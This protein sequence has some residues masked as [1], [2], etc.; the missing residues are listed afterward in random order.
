MNVKEFLEQY[1]RAD[2]RAKRLRREYEKE[3]CLIDTITSPL[4]SDGT[5]H[6]S[7]IS[8]TV[9]S[10][11]IRLADKLLEYEDAEL[12]AIEIRQSVFDTI[13]K[14]DGI[15]SDILYEYYIDYYDERRQKARTW[16]EVADIVHVDPRTVYRIKLRAYKKLSLFVSI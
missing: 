12:D 6:G 7:G 14:V 15:E 3:K 5:P 8:K 2:R 16:E 11:A 4:G 10:R 1:K 9:E 13:M